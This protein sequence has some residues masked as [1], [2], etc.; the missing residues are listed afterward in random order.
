MGV[1]AK[2]SCKSVD[3]LRIDVSG[4]YYRYNSGYMSG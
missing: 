2:I 1:D 3:I 4:K